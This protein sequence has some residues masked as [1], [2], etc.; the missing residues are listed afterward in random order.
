MSCCTRRPGW[1]R[2]RPT[3]WAV[4][5]TGGTARRSPCHGST[6]S[7]R[8][9]DVQR[10]LP[11]VLPGGA[12][13]AEAGVA[14]LRGRLTDLRTAATAVLAGL[15]ADPPITGPARA[16][17]LTEED[18]ADVL[19]ARIDAAGDPAGDDTADAATLG[20]RIHALLDRRHLACRWSVPVHCPC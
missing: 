4:P 3:Y 12:A 8:L 7:A 20:S 6:A 15:A 11:D 16:W 2:S 18:A 13:A 19:V 1:T 17:G 14:D 5:V 9:L 10:G